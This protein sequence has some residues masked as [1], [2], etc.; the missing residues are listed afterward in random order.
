MRLGLS[1]SLGSVRGGGGAPVD[2]TAP[3]APTVALGIGIADGATITEATAETGV[4]T[5]NAEAGSTITVLFTGG[6]DSLTKTAIGTGSP[7]PIVLTLEDIALIGTGVINQLVTATDQ[8]G[9]VSPEVNTSLTIE[10]EAGGTFTGAP[11]ITGTRGGTLTAVDAP[12]TGDDTL[13]RSWVYDDGTIVGS[14]TTVSDAQPDRSIELINT[15]AASSETISAFRGVEASAPIYSTDFEAVAS[16][17]LLRTV[18]GWTYQGEVAYQDNQKIVDGAV[19]K[20]AT[21][22]YEGYGGCYYDTGVSSFITEVECVASTGAANRIKFRYGG[23]D[24]YIT[25]RSGQ[26]VKAYEVPSLAWVGGGVP[27]PGPYKLLLWQDDV[28]KKL[29]VYHNG[30]EF[31]FGAGSAGLDLTGRTL[32]GQFRIDMNTDSFQV[33]NIDQIESIS[34]RDATKIQVLTVKVEAIGGLGKYRIVMR[35]INAA[36]SASEYRIERENG[37]MVTGWT[38]TT[39]ASGVWT[40][41]FDIPD[42][43]YQNER[44]VVKVRNVGGTVTVASQSAGSVVPIV[45]QQK[46][47]ISMNAVGAA[48]YGGAN[49]YRDLA[50]SAQVSLQPIGYGVSTR[51][52]VGGPGVEIGPWSDWADEYNPA[53]TYPHWTGSD[54]GTSDQA[55]W[56]CMYQGIQYETSSTV[57]GNIPIN[58]PPNPAVSSGGPWKPVDGGLALHSLIFDPATGLIVK[59]PDDV[60]REVQFELAWTFP[61]GVFPFTIAGK[62]APGAILKFYLKSNT[63]LTTPVDA[64]GDFVIT[65]TGDTDD[66]S[67]IIVVDRTGAVVPKL[68][69]IP[70]YETGT[71]YV[72][73]KYLDDM[74]A[75]Y[76]A[77]RNMSGTF[78]NAGIALRPVST[79][80]KRLKPAQVGWGGEACWEFEIELAK[81]L[82]NKTMYVNTKW[83][84]ESAYKQGWAQTIATDTDYTGDV[85]VEHS[86]ENWQSG[87]GGFNQ[88]DLLIAEA[89]TLGIT[90]ERLHSRKTRQDIEIFRTEFGAQAHRIKGILAWQ[91]F[92][93]LATWKDMLDFENCYQVI[94]R[95]STAPYLG[96]GAMNYDRPD[97]PVA[98]TA[99]KNAI[100][101]DDYAAFA[102]AMDAYLIA[103]IPT[104]VAGPKALWDWL[105]NYCESKGLPWDAIQL[106]DYEINHH[107]EVLGAWP[108]LARA[109]TFWNTYKTS[110]RLSAILTQFIDAIAAQCPHTIRMFDYCG[111]AGRTAARLSTDGSGWELMRKT[112]DLAAHPMSAVIERAAHYN[113]L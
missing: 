59:H 112:G 38:A 29:H 103:A 77:P 68:E 3:A 54:F 43:E 16:G 74:A 65:V 90:R 52:V 76:D 95:I 30:E 36:S 96:T 37:E 84:D 15:L 53:L 100:A 11:A 62:S 58:T 7:V 60:N 17:D 72:S 86:N 40:A 66:L 91:T 82:G 44:L 45:S 46:M 105:P 47:R 63:T 9:N 92:T 32:N 24:H 99:V 23:G 85:D 98:S 111:I 79:L 71:G 26:E 113:A 81:K 14:G 102:D 73:Q 5:V 10:A 106:D 41:S 88:G 89:A 75:F 34:F 35:G 87:N 27:D 57:N 104:A 25:V 56:R 18:P 107:V 19:Q 94:S 22:P 48:V 70:S 80:A 110:S 51:S 13:S 12:F 20:T 78:V 55:G 50:K 61:V 67:P 69:L 21:Y 39:Q 31:D 108:N 8:A 97:M 4:I 49:P 93:S 42:F 2:T 64:N 101:A 109:K 28:N 83:F 1:L 6:A 33:L